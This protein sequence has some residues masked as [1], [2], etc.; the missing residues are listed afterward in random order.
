MKGY[1]L[2]SSTL[3]CYYLMLLGA[4]AV[5]SDDVPSSNSL[6]L[7]EGRLLVE[8]KT[9]TTTT[10]ITQT[11]TA[12]ATETTSCA[13]VAAGLSACRKRRNVIEEPIVINQG[14]IQGPADSHL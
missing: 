2:K 1:L 13:T 10:T 9:F 14:V 7:G 8:P 4:A 3:L 11:A 12:T 6:S 5:R